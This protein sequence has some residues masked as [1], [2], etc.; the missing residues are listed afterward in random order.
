MVDAVTFR[1]E[2]VLDAAQLQAET[3]SRGSGSDCS[4]S[5]CGNISYL[6]FGL[7]LGIIIEGMGGSACRGG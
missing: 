5:L 6:P 1:G 3:A 4:C 2:S 7:R